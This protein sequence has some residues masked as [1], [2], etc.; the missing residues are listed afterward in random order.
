M[1]ADKK[2]SISKVASVV[3]KNPLLTEREIA[4]EAWIGNWTVHRS[5]K[6]VEQ[7]GAKEEKIIVITDRD[8]SIVEKWQREIDRRLSDTEELWK[9]RTTEI[10]QVIKESTARYTIFRWDATDEK[11]WMKLPDVTF[12]IINP[13]GNEEN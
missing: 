6:E 8:L 12:Q 5:L 13:N 9:M 1:R 10:S 4:E 11:W 7:S 3:L 2:K